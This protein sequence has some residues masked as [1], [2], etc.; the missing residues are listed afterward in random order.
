MC[1]CV[2]V[3]R[4]TGRGSRAADSSNSDV[5][6]GDLSQQLHDFVT[7]SVPELNRLRKRGRSSA[8]AHQV[9]QRSQGLQPWNRQPPE[10]L[11][12][13][14][15][16]SPN[17]GG[18]W[19]QIRCQVHRA[20]SERKLSEAVAQT[21]SR[22]PSDANPKLRASKAR[23]GGTCWPPCFCGAALPEPSLPTGPSRCLLY[24]SDAAD[25]ERLV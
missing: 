9:V 25:E 13:R 23:R 19:L 7:H 5:R 17:S 1:V 18:F 24:T 6:P 4:E 16:R 14:L 8:A 20:P 15:P 3:E 22:I 2:C 10:R 12:R 11:Q 21:E